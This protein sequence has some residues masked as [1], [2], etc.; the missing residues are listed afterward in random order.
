MKLEWDMKQATP[1]SLESIHRLIS[2]GITEVPASNVVAK[3]IDIF[4]KTEER[5][6]EMP[7]DS[8][9]KPADI[10]SDASDKKINYYL[11][12]LERIP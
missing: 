5:R 6:D 9:E 10:K 11:K 7:V 1:E 12:S 3:A 8:S 4:P 2:E